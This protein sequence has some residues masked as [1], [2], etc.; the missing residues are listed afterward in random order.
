MGSDSV[1]VEG[2]TK[3]WEIDP[4]EQMRGRMG[5][6]GDETSSVEKLSVHVNIR[7]R[8]LDSTFVNY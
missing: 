2:T 7:K 4:K 1:V 6:V 3:K 8:G 5:K